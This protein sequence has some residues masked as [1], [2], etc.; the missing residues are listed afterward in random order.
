MENQPDEVHSPDVGTLSA[1]GSLPSMWPRGPLHHREAGLR[2]IW[3]YKRSLGHGIRKV[4]RYLPKSQSYT[5]MIQ[6][7]P[8]GPREQHGCEEIAKS[9]CSSTRG[10]MEVRLHPSLV[11]WRSRTENRRRRCYFGPSSRVL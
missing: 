6:A 11:G 8:S 1:P 2:G 5:K 3:N 10:E 7:A 9:G 4:W